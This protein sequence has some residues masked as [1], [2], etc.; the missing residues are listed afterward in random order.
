MHREGKVGLGLWSKSILGETRVH[1][2]VG[3]IPM[4]RIGRVADNGID[5][6]RLV[7]L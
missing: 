2:F 4:L 7:N 3:G 6:Q 5:S 1:I